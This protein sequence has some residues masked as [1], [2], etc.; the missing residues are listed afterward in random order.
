MSNAPKP[1]SFTF[2][3]MCANGKISSCKHSA[4]EVM[5]FAN[6]S[7]IE[8]KI[9]EL[10]NQSCQKMKT[11][12]RE[13]LGEIQIKAE[14]LLRMEEIQAEEKSSGFDTLAK[15]LEDLGEKM[16]EEDSENFRKEVREYINKANI[17][18]DSKTEVIKNAEFDE[19]S[20]KQMIKNAEYEYV[21]CEA[22]T[23]TGPRRYDRGKSF[24][25][26][27]LMIS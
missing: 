17:D 16:N 15:G 14:I 25:G 3:S 7:Q 1:N 18:E 23:S 22:I 19:D 20:K 2:F 24:T 26:H 11:Q 4:D 12:V 27:I 6:S 13:N 9:N 5:D 21:P 10:C 8:N